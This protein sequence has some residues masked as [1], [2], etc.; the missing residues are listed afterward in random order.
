MTEFESIVDN[1]RLE[2]LLLIEKHYKEIIETCARTKLRSH[3]SDDQS[4]K[5]LID[6]VINEIKAKSKKRS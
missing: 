5:N 6:A 2:Y 1:A 3:N 4:N